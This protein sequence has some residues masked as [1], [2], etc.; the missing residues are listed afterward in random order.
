MHLPSQTV[1]WGFLAVQWLRLCACTAQGSG[2]IPG[3]ESSTRHE[4]WP[5]GKIRLYLTTQ[6]PHS[7]SSKLQGAGAEGLHSITALFRDCR[8]P[9]SSKGMGCS[10]LGL[11]KTLLSCELGLQHIS[12]RSWT[13]VT[14]AP[15]LD[16]GLGRFSWCR[17]E[18]YKGLLRIM[19]LSDKNILI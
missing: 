12:K 6:P 4:V 17:K 1:L 19:F 16:S 15:P 5:K 11:P 2:W 7:A 10:H 13:A 18:K 8:S 14:R 3:R 9:G